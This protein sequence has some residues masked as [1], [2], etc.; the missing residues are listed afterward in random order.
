MFLLL[1]LLLVLPLSKH[2]CSKE[3]FKDDREGLMYTQLDGIEDKFEQLE[4]KLE[5]KNVEV[6]NLEEQ[7]KEMKVQFGNKDREAAFLKKQVAELERKM[8]EVMQRTQKNQVVANRLTSEVKMQ[9]KAEVEKELDKV[10]PDA[11]EQGLRD[12][13]NE[14]ICALKQDWYEA[15]S[16]VTYDRITALLVKSRQLENAAQ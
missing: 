10:L 16:V 3:T 2:V 1:L 8:D 6:E 15:N 5:T 14:M 4:R 13:P 9:C 7:L 12:L 11:V